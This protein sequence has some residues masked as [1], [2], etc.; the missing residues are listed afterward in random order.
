M[1]PSPAISKVMADFEAELIAIKSTVD[2]EVDKVGGGTSS[3]L[4]L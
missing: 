2:K 1:V 4:Q 3:F